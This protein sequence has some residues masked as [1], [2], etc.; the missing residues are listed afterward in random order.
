MHEKKKISKL[1]FI[2][3]KNVCSVKRSIKVTKRQV[4]DRKKIFVKHLSNKELVSNMYKEFL[5]INNRPSMV[6]DACDPSRWGG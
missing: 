1:D 4:T 6:A 3:I 2:N 5:K